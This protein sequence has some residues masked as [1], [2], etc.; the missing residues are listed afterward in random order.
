MPYK[1]YITP[2]GSPVAQIVIQNS[3]DYRMAY[4]VV[5]S[6]A[7]TSG[8]R[9]RVNGVDLGIG[10]LNI[11][12]E[13]NGEVSTEVITSLNAGDAISLGVNGTSVTL[14]NIGASAFLSLVQ[15]S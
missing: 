10:H 3:G 2:V 9:I 7:I 14:A 4:G 1:F 12:V 11:V 15:L 5:C 6:S 8:L 13:S